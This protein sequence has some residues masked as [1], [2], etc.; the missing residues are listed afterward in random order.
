MT[1]S[2][3]KDMAD[4]IARWAAGTPRVRRVW[5]F[6]NGAPQEA[7]GN[8]QIE[9]ALELEPVGDSEE[10]LAIWMANAG[11][12]QSQ[13]RNRVAAAVELEWFDPDGGA[14]AIEG[15]LSEEK[16]LVYERA[17]LD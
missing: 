4:S 14:A 5:L 15:R 8:G 11:S 6:A 3:H 10:T 12:W 9:V 16:A 13:L 1:K 7:R 17:P 2:K